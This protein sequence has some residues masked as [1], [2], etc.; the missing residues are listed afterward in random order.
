[1]RYRARMKVLHDRLTGRYFLRNNCDDWGSVATRAGAG[2]STAGGSTDTWL[3]HD[4]GTCS[5]LLSP[6]FDTRTTRRFTTFTR[7]TLRIDL[8]A[9]VVRRRR[10]S[11]VLLQLEAEEVLVVADHRGMGKQSLYRLKIK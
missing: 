11:I 1:M 10:R 4:G 7:L 6:V 9:R 8:A 3:C 5:L 2:T